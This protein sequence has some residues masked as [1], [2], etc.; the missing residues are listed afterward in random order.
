M[1]RVSLCMLLATIALATFAQ[2]QGQKG[3]GQ[4]VFDPQ[5]Y[6]QMVEESLTKAACM[7]PE[8][9]KAFFPLYN[10]MRAKQRD[11]GR[12]IYEVKKNTSGNDNKAYSDAILKINQLKVKMAEVEQDFYKRIIKVVPAEKAFKVMKA[13]D[14]FHRRMVQ[15][16]RGRRTA[17]HKGGPRPMQ[18]K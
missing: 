10:E 12:Q 18:D 13:E 8:E 15:G 9:A 4:P 14:D 2:P 16:Q 3:P 11:M 6:Q 7:I 5:K 1:K 17:N